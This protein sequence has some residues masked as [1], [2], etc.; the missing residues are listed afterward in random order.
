[1]LKNLILIGGGLGVLAWMVY[2]MMD[3]RQHPRGGI[4]QNNRVGVEQRPLD[5]RT[6]QMMQDAERA[7]ER[8]MER[9]A[10]KGD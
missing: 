10:G 5:P 6:V 7:R 9:A 1:M 2:P 8:T 3:S 4:N